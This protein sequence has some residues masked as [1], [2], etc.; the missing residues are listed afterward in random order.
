MDAFLHQVL[1][2]IATGGIYAA[3]ALALASSLRDAPLDAKLVVFGELGLTGEVR[4]VPHG[5]ERLR[6]R[7]E[8]VAR[9]RG[10]VEVTLEHLDGD[11]LADPR[12]AHR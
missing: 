1:S 6:E 4:P 7:A 5:E 12:L 11:G 10:D 2:G 3:V 9:G 8:R